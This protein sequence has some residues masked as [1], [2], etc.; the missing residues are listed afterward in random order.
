MVHLPQ[1]AAVVV[2]EE[3][4]KVLRRFNREPGWETLHALWAFP[5]AVL[6]P[7]SRG[8]RSRWSKTSRKVRDRATMFGMLGAGATWKDGESLAPKESSGRR[9]PEAKEKRLQ[10]TAFVERVVR[11]VGNGAISK[12]C[13]LLV[14][15]GVLDSNQQAVMDKLRAL[16]PSEDVPPALD[17]EGLSRLEF[18]EEPEEVRERCI[19]LRQAIFSFPKESAP[20]PSG[21]RPDHLKAMVGEASGELGDELLLELDR[22]VCRG[23]QDGFHANMASILCSAK[24][25]PLRK[26]PGTVEELDP[27]GNPVDMATSADEGIRPIASGKTLR[28]LTGKC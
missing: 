12:A 28:R 18:S 20:G 14:S 23:L 3:Y 17:K 21:L 8:G 10:D 4:T 27:F 22:F 26:K 25:T 1:G 19:A 11:A 9:M 16:H 5:K 2:T 24:L 13:Q 7:L 6:A 15:D